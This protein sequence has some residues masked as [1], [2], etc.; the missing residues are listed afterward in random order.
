MTTIE[1]FTRHLPELEVMARAWFRG[2]GPEA[3][4]EAIQN[5]TCLAWQYWLRLAEQGRDDEPGLLRNVWW[6]AIKQTRVGRTIARGDGMRG[7]GKQDAFDR[8]HGRTI[9]H[10]D[11]NVFVGDTT[12]IPDAVAFR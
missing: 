5:T 9:E 2:I 4:D 7:R 11:F 3:R 12:P 6:F 8:V 1:M 10:I